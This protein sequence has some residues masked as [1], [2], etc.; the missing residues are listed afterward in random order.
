MVNVAQAASLSSAEFDWNTFTVTADDNDVT[1]SIAWNYQADFI[2][3]RYIEGAVSGTPNETFHNIDP[4]PEW[5]ISQQRNDG[6]LATDAITSVTPNLV[7][8]ETVVNFT[9]RAESDVRRFGRFTAPGDGQY[10]FSLNYSLSA[11][12]NSTNSETGGPANSLVANPFFELEIREGTDFGDPDQF[13][14]VLDGSVDVTGFGNDSNSGT[15]TVDRENADGSLFDFKEGDT[16]WVTAT[17]TSLSTS[18]SSQPPTTVP[19]PP[20]LILFMSGLGALVAFGRKKRPAML[21]AAS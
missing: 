6:G 18:Y 1:S 7:F 4:N 17:A 16:I 15:I 2:G 9:G 11:E 14:F 20:A 5:A 19:V 13:G 3:T 8:A 10:A 12:V 21:A